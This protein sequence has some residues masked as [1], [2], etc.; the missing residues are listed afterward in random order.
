MAKAPRKIA[1]WQMT[2]PGRMERATIDLPELRPGEVLVEIAGCGICHSDHTAFYG[3]MPTVMPRTL[4]HEISGTIVAGDPDLAG[5]EVIIPA[6]MPCHDCPICRAGR[7]NRCLS[8][9]IP[10]YTMGVYGGNASHIVVPAADLCRIRERRG[11]PLSHF[12]VVA[13]VVASA[14]QAAKRAC[15]QAGDLTAVVGATGC[16]GVYATQICAAMGAREVIGIGRNQERLQRALAFGATH[17]IN[18][19]GKTAQG[20]RHEF[21]AYC[22]S[23]GLPSDYGWKVFEWTGTAAGQEIALELLSFTGKLVIGGFGRH[24]SEFPLSRLMALEA[25]IIGSWACLPEYYPDI[26]AM[27]QNGI[28]QIEPFV[29]TMPMSRIGEAY[30]EAHRG[31]LKQRIVLVPDF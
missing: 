16:A 24:K 28:V 3:G 26:L 23:K 20:V 9:K 19:Q 22:R 6:A 4:G 31:G 1:I 7:G 11:V 25:D 21:N 17:V 27:V 5:A 14:Y 8:A 15:V 13:D 2:A 10:G 12:A 29:K 30:E 18:C